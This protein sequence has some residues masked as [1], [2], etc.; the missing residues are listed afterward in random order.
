[1]KEQTKIKISYALRNRKKSAT[2]SYR[3]A[4]SLKG[5]KKSDEHKKAISNAMKKLWE[6]RRKD[7]IYRGVKTCKFA[8][9]ITG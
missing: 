1:M 7:I 6:Q 4:E 2:H 3:I 9:L 8:H 5:K